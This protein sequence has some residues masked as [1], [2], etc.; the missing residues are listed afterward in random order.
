MAS[1]NGA[2]AIDVGCINLVD[3]AGKVRASLD[4]DATNRVSMRMFDG[5]ACPRIII[6]V[7]K[8]GD[9]NIEMP[10]HEDNGGLA[11]GNGSRDGAAICMNNPNGRFGIFM[12]VDKNAVP[13]VC[14]AD[15]D[16]NTIQQWPIEQDLDLG[17]GL[18]N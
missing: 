11:I 2:K 10:S 17:S 6:S 4:I 18:D 9:A 13:V 3:P 5:N 8:N 12:R 15:K 1:D 7:A 16:G 14:I